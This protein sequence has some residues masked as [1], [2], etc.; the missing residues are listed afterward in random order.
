MKKSLLKPG[1]N[2]R[3]L[4]FS[5]EDIKYVGMTDLSVHVRLKNGVLYRI[6]NP[7]FAKGLQ[8]IRTEK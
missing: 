7:D 1:V 8:I 4:N 2:N 5:A 3:V 6:T